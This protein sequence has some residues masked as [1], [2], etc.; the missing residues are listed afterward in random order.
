MLEIF[1]DKVNTL[2]FK[3]NIQGNKEKPDVRFII[4]DKE[5]I[6]LFFP[7]VILNDVISVTIPTLKFLLKDFELTGDVYLEILVEGNYY[8]PWRDQF[9]LSNS[10]VLSVETVNEIPSINSDI[11]KPSFAISVEP[12]NISNLQEEVKSEAKQE[13][14][15]EPI[16]E[17]LQEEEVKEPI[18]ENINPIPPPIIE[19]KKTDIIL[20]K[21]YIIEGLQLPKGKVLTILS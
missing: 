3:L 19:E 6:N 13:E 18:K 2:Q 5:N 9:I 15:I 17:E 10:V 12:Q 4:T 20:T 11:Q 1:K 14:K 21:N 16:K 8:V 7:G